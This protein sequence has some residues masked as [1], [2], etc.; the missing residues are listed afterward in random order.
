MH[1][2]VAD[3]GMWAPL[4]PPLS[5]GHRVIAPDLRGWG[6]S[7][8]PG[9]E[10]ADA[11][12]LAH[13]LD[14]LGIEQAHVVGASFGGRVALELATRHPDRVVSLALLCS[15]YRGL[16]ETDPAVIEFDA[17]EEALLASGDVEGAVA[18]NVDTWAG[19]EAS[20]AARAELA[21]MQRRAF[22]VQL[23]ADELDPPPQPER[24]EVDPTVVTA[25][26]TVVSGSHDL[27]HFRDVAALLAR[28][29]PG[30]RLVELDW[31]GH[32]PAMERPAETAALILRH[33]ENGPVRPVV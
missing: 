24:V 31:A 1:A 33:L 13:L 19:P 4:V 10:Y 17:R 3:R 5:A 28:E 12:D 15:A 30:A 27:A 14:A 8:L 32:L 21:R 20:D 7:P 16:E 2:G 29:I 25:P 11:D 23:A 22:D 6:E 18:L 9:V 26:A